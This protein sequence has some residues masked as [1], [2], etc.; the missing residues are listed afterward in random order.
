MV[1]VRIEQFAMWWVSIEQF[2]LGD[3]QSAMWWESSE[4]FE[5]GDEQSACL[6]GLLVISYDRSP[7][8]HSCE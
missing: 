1:G 2:E 4:Q 8:I 3:E 5:L 6:T 7:P